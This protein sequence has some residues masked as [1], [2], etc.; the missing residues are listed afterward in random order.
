MRDL[1]I[2]IREERTASVV[3]DLGRALQQRIAA[4][5][6]SLERFADRLEME[7]DKAS[8]MLSGYRDFRICEL[9]AVADALGMDVEIKLTA[10]T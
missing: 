1:P 10:R 8:H 6:I 2:S 5:E 3:V 9:V 4:L 7:P